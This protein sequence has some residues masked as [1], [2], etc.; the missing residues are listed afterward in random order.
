MWHVL[1]IRAAPRQQSQDMTAAGCRG[2]GEVYAADCVSL[3]P[4]HG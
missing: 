1:H 3:T 2:Q 4:I